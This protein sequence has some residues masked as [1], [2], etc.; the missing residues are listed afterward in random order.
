M[1]ALVQRI[2]SHGLASLGGAAGAAALW[3]PRRVLA[4]T[5]AAA[6]LSLA[7]LPGELGGSVREVL[8]EAYLAVSV[9]VT[10]TLLVV[11]V[12]E[13]R[14]GLDTAQVLAKHRAWQVPVAVALG[15]VPGCGG[16]ILVVT[17]F[18]K[19]GISLGALIG[20]LTAT[21]GD[22]AFLLLAAQP[23]VGLLV[24]AIA[25]MT[26]LIT[27]LLVD[28]LHPKAARP[29]GQ[30]GSGPAASAVSAAP[31]CTLTGSRASSARGQALSLNPRPLTA[32]LTV[33]AGDGR[34]LPAAT[35]RRSLVDHLV[36]LWLVLA[37]PG[38]V[39]GVLDLAAVDTSAL[40]A[41]IGLPGLATALGVTGSVL[42][43]VLWAVS[44][45]QLGQ[46]SRGGEAACT[47]GEVGVA[48]RVSQ[49]SAFVLVWVVVAFL[50]YEGSVAVLGVDLGAVAAAWAGLLPL[51]AVAVG[52][53]PGCGPQ[54]V[55][56]ALYLDGALPF[57]ALMANAIGNDGDA[58]LP[59]IAIAP[60]A[61]ILATAYSAIPALV[62]GYALFAF[63]L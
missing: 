31:S 13:Q 8:A 26:G 58:L 10:A 32:T 48:R 29:A 7:L 56:T 55:V 63:G 4:L 20:T 60:R 21:M 40:L 44:P 22:A 6:L 50:A 61:A 19:G 39:V 33:A 62:V 16:A 37:A 12:V 47:R 41:R 43:L 49:D 53:I 35:R 38:L 14:L 18:A 46:G 3:P 23:A 25:G 52:L 2:R 17:A 28:W 59:A 24:I 51:L 15:L 36:G 27:G 57:S 54:I 42:A 1:T 11:Y 45:S 9:F 34:G 5:A 30:R